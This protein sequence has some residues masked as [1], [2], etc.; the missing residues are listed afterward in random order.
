[1]IICSNICYIDLIPKVYD[2]VHIFHFLYNLLPE[3]G[4]MYLLDL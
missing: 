1:M 2:L 4:G 3:H